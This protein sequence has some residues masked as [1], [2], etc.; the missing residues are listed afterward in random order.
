MRHGLA[1]HIHR[2]KL[3]ELCQRDAVLRQ[4]FTPGDDFQLRT[5]NLLLHVQVGNALYV[6]HGILNLISQSEHTVQVIPEELDGDARL[7]AAQH[8]IDAV[9]DGLA[10]LDVGSGNDRKLAAHLVEQFP[11]RAVFQF[12]G[13]FQ[14]GHV[15][16]QR[17]FVQLGTPRLACHGLYFGNGKQDFLCL[18][19]YLV[20]LFQRNARQGTDIDGERTFVERGQ[21]AVSQGK[22]QAQCHHKKSNGTRQY[23]PLVSQC[24]LQC[25]CVIRTEP[26]G[27]ESFARQS[28]L[29]S[30]SQQ[31]TAKY[32]RKG[33]CHHR[34]SKQGYDESDAQR[35]QH[36]PLH[37]TQEEQGHEAHN[38]NQRRVE[39]GHTHLAR[40][41]EHHFPHRAAFACR[42]H[43]VLAQ[44]LP[45]IL[46]VYDGIVYQRTDGYR[47]TAQTHGIDAQPH[48]M[49]HQNS[50]HQRQGKRDERNHRGAH[51]GKEKEEH[52]NYEYRP[53]VERMLHVADGTFDKARLA[54]RIGGYT[55][56]GRKVLLQVFQ[57]GFQLFGQ[58]DGARIGLLGHGNQYGRF[59][60][61]RCQS[62]LGL[63]GTDAHIR[64]IFQHNGNTS[65]GLNHRTCHFLYIFG[66]HHSA[67]NILVAI[68]INDT[69]VG[70]LV[71]P[72]GHFHHL[73]QRNAVMFHP[74][75]MKQNLVFFDIA[76]QYRHLCHASGREQARA[77]GPVGKRTQVE[78]RSAV[79]G[80]PYNQQFTQNG[81]LGSQC[82]IAHILRQ[83]LAHRSKFFGYNLAGK[84]DIGIPVE[85]YP[86]HRET[87]GRRRAH[88][89]YT[90]STVHRGL[91]GEGDELF[92]FFRRHSPGFG[93][94]HHRG[95]VQVGEHIHLGMES[96]VGSPYEQKHRCH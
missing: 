69:S 71:H 39:D 85:L 38:D 1:R 26:H 40:G 2:D 10:Y 21:K 87:G 31:I 22:E 55:H 91:D 75:R 46:H 92:H 28:F 27:K 54:E 60:F 29:L 42:K 68:F 83:A 58:F 77:D 67:H 78:H 76:S 51:I 63:L 86:Y 50:Y 24:P 43:P 44:M 84:V 34:R 7:R 61:L 25:P 56:I 11:V 45:Y 12:E 74:L 57:G 37:A 59:P 72:A 53:F 36:P 94:H 52:D 33:K 62:Q 96:G 15:H 32:R 80:K 4:H 30:A 6:F 19:P 81:R 14:L 13:S 79:G 5:L 88:P 17:M 90:R 35:H 82:R 66:R 9:A 73:A 64:H 48:V 47:H 3:I 18:P 65:C 49:Q 16:A 41:V 95:R 93:H 70:I 8:G 89:A 23:A 20:G